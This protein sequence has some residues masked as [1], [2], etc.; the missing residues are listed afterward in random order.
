[1][2]I[3]DLVL[4]GAVGVTGRKVPFEVWGPKGTREMM[5][6]IE[7]AFSADIRS[8]QSSEGFTVLSHDINEGL[9]LEDD[10]L[11][12][13][14]FPVNHAPFAPAFGYRIDFRGRSVALSG[15]TD[16]AESLIKAAAGVDV[17]I[18]EAAGGT[19]EPSVFTTAAHTTAEQVGQ[20]FARVK[21]PVA[22]I[23]HARNSEALLAQTRKHY[24]GPLYGPEDLLAIDIAE[25]ID[26]RR[27][28]R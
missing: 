12:V 28:K 13:T 3:P 4:A 14:A 21:P 8:R 24:N 2:Q 7:Q 23:S 17:L 22:V 5:T 11:R 27:P 9:I 16:V 25:T 15:D 19:G 26:V 1:M 6:L 18:H 10:G 20:V